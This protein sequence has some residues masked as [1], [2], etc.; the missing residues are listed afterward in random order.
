ME[1]KAYRIRESEK[2]GMVYYKITDIKGKREMEVAIKDNIHEGLSNLGDNALS[3]YILANVFSHSEVKVDLEKM[4]STC[5]NLK[6]FTQ[7]SIRGY[8]L[9]GGLRGDADYWKPIKKDESS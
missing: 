2:D 4:C 7:C 5:G 1:F 9:R 8:C 3:N 6:G